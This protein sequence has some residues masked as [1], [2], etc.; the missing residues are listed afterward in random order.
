MNS[1][2]NYLLAGYLAIW[3]ILGVYLLSLGAR[4]KRTEAHLRE[5]EQRLSE[6][7]AAGQ[8]KGA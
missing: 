5:L 1:G 7:D 4:Q 3:V 8:R 6:L 2:L